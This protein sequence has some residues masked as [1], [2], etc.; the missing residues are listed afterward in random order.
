[1]IMCINL[2]T[3]YRLERYHGPGEYV[4]LYGHMTS[5]EGSNMFSAFGL[6][7]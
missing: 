1:M 5:Q 2:S 6:A 7:L 4:R 3:V